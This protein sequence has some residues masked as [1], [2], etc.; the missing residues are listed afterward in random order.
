MQNKFLLQ[1]ASQTTL[2]SSL[3]L[4]EIFCIEVKIL[5]MVVTKRHYSWYFQN[6]VCLFCAFPFRPRVEEFRSNFDNLI[7]NKIKI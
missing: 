2:W 7:L 6:V 5:K 4:D 1:N 3:I